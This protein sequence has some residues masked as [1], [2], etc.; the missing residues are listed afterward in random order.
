MKLAIEIRMDSRRAGLLPTLS[1]TLPSMG[2]NMN[3]IKEN[4]AT[5]TP[6]AVDPAWKL[7]A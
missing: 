6:K 7:S 2:A 5:R 4:E 3:C 1:D